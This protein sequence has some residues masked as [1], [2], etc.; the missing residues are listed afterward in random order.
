M[1]KNA[2]IAHFFSYYGIFFFKAWAYLKYL[3]N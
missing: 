3:V 1:E 2:L